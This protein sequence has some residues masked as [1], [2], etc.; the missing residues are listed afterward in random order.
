MMAELRAKMERKDSIKAVKDSIT[1]NTPRILETYAVPD[2]MQYKRLLMW[3]HDR[4]FNELKLQTQDTSY[5]YHFRDLPYAKEDINA[6][7]LG[8]SGS[9]VQY[10]DW[11]KRE[12]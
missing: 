8:V 4:Y 2:S 3:N 10:F 6:N 12:G 11:F 5:N 7:W 1:Q 9:A